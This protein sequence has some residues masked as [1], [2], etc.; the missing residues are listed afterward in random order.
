MVQLTRQPQK[1]VRVPQQEGVPQAIQP[2]PQIQAS[3]LTEEKVREIVLEMLIHYGL[4]KPQ[5]RMREIR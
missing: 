4:I 2:R 1:P 3:T 5:E